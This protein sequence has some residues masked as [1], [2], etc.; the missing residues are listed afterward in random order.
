LPLQV[1]QTGARRAAIALI[2]AECRN[3]SGPVGF[4]ILLNLPFFA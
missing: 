4:L 3:K 2:S 1:I